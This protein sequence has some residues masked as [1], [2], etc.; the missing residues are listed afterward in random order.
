MSITY[1]L[2]K[3]DEINPNFLHGYKRYYHTTEMYYLKNQELH[4]TTVHF[5]NIWE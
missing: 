3:P 2:C 4:T 5:N 1:R